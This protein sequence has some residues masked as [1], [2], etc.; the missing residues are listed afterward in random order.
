MTPNDDE[1]RQ[2]ME[3]VVAGSDEAASQLLAR[4]G[5]AVLQA[6]RRRLNRQL[7]SKFDSLDFVQD[8]WASFFANPPRDGQLNRP[9]LLVAFLT[10]VAKNKVVDATRQRMQGLK[11]NVNRER[12]LDRSTA[13]GPAQVPAQQETPSQAVSR[14]EEWLRLLDAQPVVYRR[15]LIMLREGRKPADIAQELHIHPRTI[16]RLIDKLVPRSPS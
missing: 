13:G 6:V 11:H 2:L 10:R 3:R 1:F 9:E 4:Y 15:I 12:S 8:V 16:R 5:A 14:D 7:R